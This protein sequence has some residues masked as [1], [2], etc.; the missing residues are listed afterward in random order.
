MKGALLAPSD[1]DRQLLGG[2]EPGEAKEDLDE[3]IAGLAG[4]FQISQGEA[5]QLLR[6]GEQMG[7]DVFPVPPEGQETVHG[8]VLQ[9]FFR[10]VPDL[11][12]HNDSLYW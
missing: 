4:L 3:R 1:H 5:V 12:F 11:V 2:L 9:K 10:V 8:A 6:L 7:M